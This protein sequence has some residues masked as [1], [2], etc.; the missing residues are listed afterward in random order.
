MDGAVAGVEDERDEMSSRTA[1]LDVEG[2]PGH[3]QRVELPRTSFAFS[4]SLRIIVSDCR[5]ACK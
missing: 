2:E 4:K 3:V 5:L 1:Q